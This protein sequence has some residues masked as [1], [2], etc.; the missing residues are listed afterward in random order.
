MFYR[1]KLLKWQNK[2]L[3]IFFYKFMRKICKKIRKII[4]QKNT[5]LFYEIKFQN[6]N[7]Y[8]LW[9]TLIRNF[10]MFWNFH[11]FIFKKVL[12]SFD[13]IHNFF[14]KFILFMIWSII[15]SLYH[16]HNDNIYC[17][18]FF[19]AYIIKKT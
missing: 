15:L 16:I 13:V 3:K 17:F 11:I 7:S 9:L 10:S 19:V 1:N 18:Y 6:L 12:Y 14:R 5:T 4:C 8:K 2:S